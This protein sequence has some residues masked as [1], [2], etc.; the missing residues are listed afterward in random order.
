MCVVLSNV[1]STLS[2]VTP[3]MFPQTTVRMVNVHIPTSIGTPVQVT[4]VCVVL[5]G[6]LPQFDAKIL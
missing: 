1:T 3:V 2:D 4:L 5:V 6:Q